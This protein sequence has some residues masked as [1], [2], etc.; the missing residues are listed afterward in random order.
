MSL[1]PPRSLPSSTP[2]RADFAAVFEHEVPEEKAATL[3]AA[4]KRFE[5]ALERLR[6]HEARAA[7]EADVAEAS[8]SEASLPEASV[9][10]KEI[11]RLLVDEAARTLWALMIQRDILGLRGTE[12]LIRD[13]DVPAAVHARVGVVR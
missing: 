9:R 4:T 3:V 6:A 10:E 11:Q 8:L 7:A 2:G 12:R 13:Y 1:R 5:T